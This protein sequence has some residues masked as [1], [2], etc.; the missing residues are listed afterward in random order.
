MN[1]FQKPN[2]KSPT[3]TYSRSKEVSGTYMHRVQD[4]TLYNSANF[5]VYLYRNTPNRGPTPIKAPGSRSSGG[6]LKTG[7]TEEVRMLMNITKSFSNLPVGTKR[8]IIDE[9][10]KAQIRVQTSLPKMSQSKVRKIPFIL[11]DFHIR[12]T[13]PGFARNDLGG[14]FTR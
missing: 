5:N 8:K 7:K 11:N 12:E 14:F 9:A 6:F 3:V 4:K 13:N 2:F 1:L 10:T